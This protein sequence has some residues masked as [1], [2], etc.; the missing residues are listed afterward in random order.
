[1]SFTFLE[2]TADVAF[3]AW[4]ASMEEAFKNAALALTDVLTDH[5]RIKK[6]Q[7]KKIEVEAED[8]EELLVAWLDELVFIFDTTNL[9][10][11][12]FE[13]AIQIRG[14]KFRLTANASGEKFDPAIHPSGTEVKGVS[15][16]MLKIWKDQ[17]KTYVR[18]ILDV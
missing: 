18:V 10:F 8:K 5:T 16:H 9:V 11:S 4:G 6:R 17:G 14:E 3:K 12:D 15:Y 7:D 1:M 13:I 2:H